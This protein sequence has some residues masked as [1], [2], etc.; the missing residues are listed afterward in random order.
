[1]GE[2]YAH[3]AQAAGINPEIMHRIAA[4]GSAAMDI[5]PHNGAVITLLA[6]CSLTHRESYLDLFM[7]GSLSALLSSVLVL[8]LNAVFGTF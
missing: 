3:A 1:M 4:L 2:Y 7:V 5:L 6:I 8:V